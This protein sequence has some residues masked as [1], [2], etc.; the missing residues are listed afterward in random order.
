MDKVRFFFRERLKAVNFHFVGGRKVFFETAYRQF[1]IGML[2]TIMYAKEKASS[3]FGFFFFFFFFFFCFFH[4]F[5]CGFTDE[6][7][8]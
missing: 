3:V 1:R 4:L 2:Y 6:T 5:L 8:S 7:S